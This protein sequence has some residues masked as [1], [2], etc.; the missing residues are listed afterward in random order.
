MTKEEVA[1][2]YLNELINSLVQVAE[3]INDTRVKTYRIHDLW[4]EI[5][6]S[7]SGE[8]N[9][10][11]LAGEQRREWPEKARRLSINNH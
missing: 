10:V 5:I 4:P 11:T 3:L 6:V 1:E 8:Q 2:G 9:I 7:K